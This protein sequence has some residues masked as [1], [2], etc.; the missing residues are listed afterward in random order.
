MTEIGQRE[1]ADA[2][3]PVGMPGPFHVQVISKIERRLDLLSLQLIYDHA[4][5]DAV[6]RYIAM[7]Q[8]V[9][10]FADIGQRH[11]PN[12]A[13]FLGH[14]EIRQSLVMIVLDF[15]QDYVSGIAFAHNGFAQQ[16][17]ILAVSQNVTKAWLQ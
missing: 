10:P 14:E 16:Q 4:I 9:A 15:H 1:L 8:T 5:V 12:A 2:E 7:K 6:N 3:I 11:R 13:V 17:P